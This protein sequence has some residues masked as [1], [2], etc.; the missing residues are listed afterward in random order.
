MRFADS[1]HKR[2]HRVSK[3]NSRILKSKD[4]EKYE[5]SSINLP[6]YLL[7]SVEFSDR[8]GYIVENKVTSVTILRKIVYKEPDSYEKDLNFE[9]AVWLSEFESLE[10]KIESKLKEVDEYESKLLGLASDISKQ[11]G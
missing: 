2:L 5:V 4:G 9:G 3:F 6:S 10:K 7:H 1:F 11:L 8:F